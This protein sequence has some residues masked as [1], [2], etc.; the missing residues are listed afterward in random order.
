MKD[1]AQLEKQ[2]GYTFQDRD[3]L[4]TALTHS[5]YLNEHGLPKTACNERLEFL[6]DAILEMHTSLFL[7]RHFPNEME[8]KL[9]K[10]RASIVC[11]KALSE[12]ARA[13]HLGDYLRLSHGMEL[14]GGNTSDALLSDAFEALLAAVYLDGGKKETE[15]LVKNYVDANL[16]ERLLQGD[17]KT[18]LQEMLQEQ[19]QNVEYELLSESGPEHEKTF[20]VEARIGGRAFGRGTGSSKKAAQQAAAYETIKLL[21]NTE[22]CI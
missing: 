18:I 9:S 19:G 5:S 16:D 20:V 8:G 3:L 12:S 13:L 4:L 2:I 10:Y 7:F 6:G 11:E 15:N 21:R 22:T 17:S 14:S 1:L